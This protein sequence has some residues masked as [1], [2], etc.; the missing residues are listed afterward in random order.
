MTQG[1]YD[2]LRDAIQDTKGWVG[3]LEKRVENLERESAQNLSK[4]DSEDSEMFAKH[5]ERIKKLELFSARAL[6]IFGAAQI[7][8]FFLL[9]VLGK[10]MG[11][12]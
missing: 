6:I 2:S 10:K 5:D 8:I 3:R 9:N 12:I 7:I 1:L 11:W 4:H